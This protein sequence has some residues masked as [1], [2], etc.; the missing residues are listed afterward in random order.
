[1]RP[2][3]LARGDR[4][5]AGAIALL[6]QALLVWALVLGLRVDLPAAV[7]DALHVF[8]V[9][10]V[11]PPPPVVKTIP[12][13]QRSHRPR[14]AAAPPALK[15]AATDLVVP[16]PVI[17]PPAPPPIV[18]ATTPG[19]GIAPATGNADRPGIGTGTGGEGNG[20]GSGGSGNGDGGD[21]WTPPRLTRGLRRGDYPRAAAEAEIQGTVT[22]RYRVG[23][24]GR[25]TQCRLV[26]SSGSAIL[27]EATCPLAELR[28]RYRPALDADGRPIV[29]MVTREN[30]WIIDDSFPRGR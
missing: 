14:G 16:P 13:R 3:F 19:T 17:P 21:R 22:V 28:F 15:A 20:A 25:V 18:A 2:T 11:P 10:P 12:Q 24:D 27:D 7:D 5:G 26:K 23:T 1:M 6:L 8:A 9:G 30:D 4:L 29:T